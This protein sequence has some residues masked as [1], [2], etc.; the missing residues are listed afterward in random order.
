MMLTLRFKPGCRPIRKHPAAGDLVRRSEIDEAFRH[1]E[2]R[3]VERPD[4][5][6]TAQRDVA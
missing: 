2:M 5:L 4:S 3:G 1:R 6:A